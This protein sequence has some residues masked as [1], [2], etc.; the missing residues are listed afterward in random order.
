MTVP[1][2]DKFKDYARY[3]LFEYDSRDIRSGIASRSTRNG[4]RMAKTGRYSSAP[5][6]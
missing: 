1:K 4:P 5:S 3:A 6:P 2:N